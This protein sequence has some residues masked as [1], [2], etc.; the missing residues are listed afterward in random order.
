MNLGDKASAARK[1]LLTVLGRA[2]GATVVVHLHAA[3]LVQTYN[4]AGPVVR[5]MI[6][7]P[8]RVASTNIVLGEVWRRWLIDELGVAP[9]KVDILANGVPSAPYAPRDHLSPRTPVRLL[10]L[11]NLMERKGVTDLIEALALLPA[12]LPDWSLTLAGGGEIERYRGLAAAR[13][14]TERVVGWVGSAQALALLGVVDAM[15]LPSYDEG[16]PLVILEALGAG[17]PVVCTPVGA[18]PE[19]LQDGETALFVAP[20]DQPGLAAALGRVIAEP[21]LRQHLGDTGRSSYQRTFSL[22]A[23]QSALFDIYRRQVGIDVV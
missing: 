12:D 13:G 1:G 23:F 2:M 9:G 15:V 14:L 21:A 10:F 7:L 11:G 3:K 4:Q 18:I 17:T 5:W 6:T 8:F 16:L 19:F 20:G 22:E